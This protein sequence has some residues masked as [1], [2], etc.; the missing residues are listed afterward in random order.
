MAEILKGP[1]PAKARQVSLGVK[2]GLHVKG[3]FEEKGDVDASHCRE[4]QIGV[5]KFQ[6]FFEKRGLCDDEIP[7]NEE[8][9][10]AP[11]SEVSP[12][13]MVLES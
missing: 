5:N 10:E 12:T 2:S 3:S 4:E 8:G 9:L 6:H 1:T 11:S 13:I 7:E